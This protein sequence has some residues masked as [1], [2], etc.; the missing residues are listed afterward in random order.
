[1]LFFA[2]CIFLILVLNNMFYF[3]YWLYSL[4][5]SDIFQCL[6]WA[7]Q[8]Y[9]YSV[10]QFC[11]LFYLFYFIG[12]F[13][14]FSALS[15]IC[16]YLVFFFKPF[17]EQVWVSSKIQRKTPRFPTCTW[18]AFPNISNRPGTVVQLSWSRMV[19]VIQF[20]SSLS[21]LC[22]LHNFSIVH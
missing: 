7:S 19:L 8:R 14:I 3:W 16:F 11:L 9:N 4:S 15:F 21:K 17:L 6:L 18:I 2:V 22:W 12:L 1:M 5:F 20:C 10:H 13:S